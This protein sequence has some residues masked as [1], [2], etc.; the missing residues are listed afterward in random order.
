MNCPGG[1][2]FGSKWCAAEFV[3]S[4]VVRSIPLFCGNFEK[5]K[6]SLRFVAISPCYDMF[7]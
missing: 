6:G 7:F 3:V 1:N 2:R 4:K 5:G